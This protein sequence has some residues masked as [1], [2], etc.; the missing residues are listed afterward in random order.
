MSCV[1][2]GTLI[3]N[4]VKFVGSFSTVINISLKVFLQEMSALLRGLF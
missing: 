1:C 4:G 2:I 3:S